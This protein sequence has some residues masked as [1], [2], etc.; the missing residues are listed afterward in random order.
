MQELGELEAEPIAPKMYGDQLEGHWRRKK[1][2]MK[3]L[4]SK[5]KATDKDSDAELPGCTSPKDGG[6][7][8]SATQE[9]LM[10]FA[11]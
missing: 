2:N 9:K 7:K 10:E 4:A 5:T 1:V 3:T 8:S 6:K 11:D